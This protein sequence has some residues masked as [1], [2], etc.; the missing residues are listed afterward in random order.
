[1]RNVG[2]QEVDLIDNTEEPRQCSSKSATTMCG[3]LVNGLE[4]KVGNK[5]G[6]RPK[7]C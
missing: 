3:L 2:R 6:G 4:E 5:E 7:G 1:V